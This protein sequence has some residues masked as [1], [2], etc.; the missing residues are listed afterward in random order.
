MPDY[1]AWAG[2]LDD[3]QPIYLQITDR[4]RES[5]AAGELPAGQRFP[6]IREVALGMRVNPNT[7][8][9]AFQEMEREGLIRSQRGVGYFVSE[10]VD[11]VEDVKH[12]MAREVIDRFIKDMQ[13]IGIGPEEII[14]L[15][16]AEIGRRGAGE[17]AQRG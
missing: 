17:E 12:T 16:R 10:D 6:P 4:F 9:R 2:A 7:V 8:N 1:Q 15:L 3:R 11:R 13:S 5:I 14:A